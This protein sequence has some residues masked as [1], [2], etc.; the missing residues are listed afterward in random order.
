MG[1]DCNK[2]RNEKEEVTTDTAKTQRII[3]YYNKQLWASM[4]TQTVKHLLAM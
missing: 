4:V 2:I 3:R 1:E